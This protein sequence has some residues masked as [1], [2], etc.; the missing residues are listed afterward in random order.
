M[1]SDAPKS[2]N[3]ISD[4]EENIPLSTPWDALRS[5]D[6]PEFKSTYLAYQRQVANTVASGEATSADGAVFYRVA[7]IH[8][9]QLLQSGHVPADISLEKYLEALAVAHYHDWQAER[10]GIP[11]SEPTPDTT[12]ATPLPDWSDFRKIRHSIWAR[13]QFFRLSKEYGYR[14]QELADDA[15]MPLAERRIASEAAA[16]EEGYGPALT[17]YK[18]LLHDYQAYWEGV[19]PSWAVDALTNKDFIAVWDRTQ[20]IEQER[21]KA[22]DTPP[23]TSHFWRNAFIVMGIVTVIA[24]ALQ[25]I[26]RPK[27]PREVYQDNFSAPESLISDLARR[28]EQS[29]DNDS[30]GIRTTLCE[31]AFRSADAAYREHNYRSAASE[32]ALVLDDTSTVC[33]SDAYFYL[34]II[35]LQIDEPGLTIECLSNIEDLSRYGEDIYWYQALAFVKM[36]IKNPLVHDKAVRAVERVISNTEIPER[37]QQAEKMLQQLNN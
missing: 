37:R 9:V 28:R 11:V 2:G 1:L 4:S 3:M 16:I 22:A 36:A 32:L 26:M 31:D 12:S 13:R 20:Q 33:H 6:S 14:I 19:L 30:L 34:A 7:V 29:P 25:W 27:T 35:G 23:E 21:A 5:P 24:I 10:K 8:L 15:A 18:N 17:A